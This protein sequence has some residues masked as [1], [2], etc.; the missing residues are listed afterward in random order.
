MKYLILTALIL[1]GCGCTD[2]RRSGIRDD[3]KLIEART[4]SINAVLEQEAALERLSQARLSFMF[5]GPGM[6]DTLELVIQKPPVE[7]VDR[8]GKSCIGTWVWI[9]QCGDTV[10]APS[11]YRYGKTDSGVDMIGWTGPID[12]FFHKEIAND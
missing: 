6:Y 3:V 12:S 5:A 4:D 11:R 7:P 2:Y 10:Y 9:N 1:V 8:T